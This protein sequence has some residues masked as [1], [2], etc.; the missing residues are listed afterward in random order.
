MISPHSFVDIFF[1]G[2]SEALA[3]NLSHLISIPQARKIIHVDR[4]QIILFQQS[5]LNRDAILKAEE[6]EILK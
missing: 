3:D 5:A 1:L 6:Y 4:T 2:L